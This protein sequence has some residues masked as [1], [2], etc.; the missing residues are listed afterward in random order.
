[1]S[2]SLHP[3]RAALSLVSPGGPRAQL[4]IL[5]FHRVLA[6]PDPLLPDLPDKVQFD[7]QMSLLARHFNVLPLAEAG[8]RLQ[9]GS[10]PTRAACITFD[11]GYRD[12]L[13]EAQP[14]L[15]RHGLPATFFVAT[16]FLDGGRM[17]NDTLIE[18]VRGLPTGPIDLSAL[19]LAVPQ[20]HNDDDRKALIK[21][22]IGH[23]KYL[24][25]AERQQAVDALAARYAVTLPDDLMLST[26]ELR[27]LHRSPGVEIGGHTCNHPILAS[28]PPEQ[29]MAEIR[30]GKAAL[31]DKLGA[32]IRLFAYPNGRPE[33]DY[34]AEHVEMVKACGFEL[35]VSTT[36]AAANRRSDLW[37]LPRFT[38]WDKTPARFGL[39]ML[40]TLAHAA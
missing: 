34:R 29:A 17:F 19:G 11:D 12:N 18:L 35:A 8:R 3:F 33:K 1:M 21:A 24:P 40:R 32:A 38:P 25:M 6:R 10:L 15:A 2:A 16:G 14:I 37:Q 31:E 7:W 9:D 22:L 4:T 27:K 30:D 26:D 5:I 13:T 23:F 20:I 28:L 39:R 36:P